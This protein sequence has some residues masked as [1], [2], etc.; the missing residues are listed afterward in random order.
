MAFVFC[1]KRRQSF[2]YL[3]KTDCRLMFL[4]NNNNTNN[5]SYPLTTTSTRFTTR[6]QSIFGTWCHATCHSIHSLF[7]SSFVLVFDDYYDYLAI[8]AMRNDDTFTKNNT[9]NLFLSTHKTCCHDNIA[10]LPIAHI[11]MSYRTYTSIQYN[12]MRLV[13]ETNETF[14]IWWRHRRNVHNWP[15]HTIMWW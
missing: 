10:I 15:Q 4:N 5:Y 9:I 13:Y 2:G 3:F 12:T 1:E 6:K 7:F 14:F 8:L 11:F